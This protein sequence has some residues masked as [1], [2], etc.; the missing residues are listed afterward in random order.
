MRCDTHLGSAFISDI[1]CKRLRIMTFCDLLF[2]VNYT[3][4]QTVLYFK[5]EKK[6]KTIPAH[7]LNLNGP[8]NS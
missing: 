3:N 1:N 7:K 4:L 5:K 8:Y 2:I 6:L